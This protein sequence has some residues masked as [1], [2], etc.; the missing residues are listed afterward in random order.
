MFLFRF[1]KNF[2]LIESAKSE[3]FI[4]TDSIKPFHCTGVECEGQSL[5]GECPTSHPFVFDDGEKCCNMKLDA[6]D[7]ARNTLRKF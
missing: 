6:N 3:F 1:Y 7:Q 4:R 2:L 5:F